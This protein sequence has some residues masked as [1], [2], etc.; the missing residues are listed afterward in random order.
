M[1]LKYRPKRPASNECILTGIKL[2][3]IES[4]GLLEIKIRTPN[5]ARDLKLI[6]VVYITDF[7]IN[8]VSKNILKLKGLYF[9]N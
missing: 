8:I 1:L 3:Q 9:D 2:V 4:Y 7:L 6:N 5:K